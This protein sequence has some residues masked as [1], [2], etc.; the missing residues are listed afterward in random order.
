MIST[1]LCR[2]IILLFVVISPGCSFPYRTAELPTAEL[3]MDE[4]DICE[5][6]LRHQ[7]DEIGIRNEMSIEQ[8]PRIKYYLTVYNLNPPT[9]LLA[10]FAGNVPRIRKGSNFE[11]AQGVI[12][13]RDWLWRI[14]T[15]KRVNSTTVDVQSG[16]YCGGLCAM[17]CTYRVVRVSDSWRIQSVIGPCMIS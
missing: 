11:I 13:G 14:D 9:A 1:N 12:V 8:L 15:I 2:L 16:Y 5:T 10:R 6:V 4:I 7:F 17:A 3:S